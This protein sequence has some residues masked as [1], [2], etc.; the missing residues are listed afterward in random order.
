[1]IERKNLRREKSRQ[2]KYI[3]KPKPDIF[4]WAEGNPEAVGLNAHWN[5][6][7]RRKKKK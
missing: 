1:M 2:S 3:P 6:N 5:K 4:G 7:S